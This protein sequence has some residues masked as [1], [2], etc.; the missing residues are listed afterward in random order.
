[1]AV[2][3]L[4]ECAYLFHLPDN[5][6]SDTTSCTQCG[7]QSLFLKQSCNCVCVV[8]NCALLNQFTYYLQHVIFTE[9]TVLNLPV[10]ASVKLQ[11]S[12]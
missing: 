10:L 3:L 1:M 2:C 5:N 8:G 9:D 7:K 12:T 4:G 6:I 11:L